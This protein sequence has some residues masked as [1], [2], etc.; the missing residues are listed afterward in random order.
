MKAPPTRQ[1]FE[2]D[3]S[4]SEVAD[5]QDRRDGEW[6]DGIR[7]IVLPILSASQP[8]IGRAIAERRCA[9]RYLIDRVL[10]CAGARLHV[11]QPVRDRSV[12][13]CNNAAIITA[14]VTITAPLGRGSS[15]DGPGRPSHSGY[16]FWSS[17]RSRSSTVSVIGF[18][19]VPM[20]AIQTGTLRNLC[21]AIRILGGK[22]R[23]LAA[24]PA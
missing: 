23:E 5:A 4:V 9:R 3:H 10:R 7:N 6:R 8:L 18:D 17:K 19:G 12:E 15:R 22:Q 20:K 24:V 21:G 13:A 14:T 1:A 2:E 11:R 16:F